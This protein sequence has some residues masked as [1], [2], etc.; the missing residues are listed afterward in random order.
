MRKRRGAAT[1]GEEGG[2]VMVSASQGRGVCKC[3]KANAATLILRN[4][5]HFRSHS[6]APFSFSANSRH[7]R[8][9]AAL[10]PGRG[11]A[12]SQSSV[13]VIS[14]SRCAL[15][16]ALRRRSPAR[17]LWAPLPPGPDRPFSLPP[18][19]H[20]GH[21]GRA[22][23]PDLLLGVSPRVLNRACVLLRSGPVRDSAGL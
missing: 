19:P 6:H 18:P 8:Y 1:G 9:N 7:C 14:H 23:A 22:E 3:G 4:V 21:W 15:P 10:G 16:A 2:M 5:F 20:Q 13:W 12:T 17:G 11:F